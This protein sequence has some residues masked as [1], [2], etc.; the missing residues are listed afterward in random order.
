V[1]SAVHPDILLVQGLKGAENGESFDFF[2]LASTLPLYRYVTFVGTTWS[3]AFFGDST[4]LSPVGV[5]RSSPFSTGERPLDILGFGLDRETQPLPSQHLGVISLAMD[6]GAD[7]A[8]IASRTL[9]AGFVRSATNVAAL[10]SQKLVVL[11]GSLA[12]LGSDE[13]GYQ[14]LVSPAGDG[15]QLFDPMEANGTWHDNR[16]FAALHT[17]STRTDSADNGLRD[18][19]DMMLFSQRLREHYVPGSYTVFGN[20]GNHFGEAVD[21]L[22]NSV[23][24]GDMAHALREASSHLPVYADFVFDVVSGVDDGDGASAALAVTPQPAN[25][26]AR[27]AGGVL[28]GR[29]ARVRLYDPVGALV[30]DEDHAPT[31]DGGVMLATAGLASGAYA[32]EVTAGDRSMRGRLVV[33][34]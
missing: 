17:S 33:V 16:S 23:V 32:Y 14:T 31:I 29:E 18:R 8:A 26:Y 24:A 20:D 2:V 27:I 15:L 5:V 6:A 30:L 25:D 4:L 1:I 7:S 13:P 3:D 9:D 28:R 21:V 10:D 19:S 22:P 34:H 11:A 12:M